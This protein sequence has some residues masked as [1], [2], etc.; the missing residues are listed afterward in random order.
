MLSLE[1]ADFEEVMQHSRARKSTQWKRSHE[2][3][4]PNHLDL[5]Y[6]AYKGELGRDIAQAK[7]PGLEAA[8]MLDEAL[9]QSYTLVL[10]ARAAISEMGEQSVARE[11]TEATLDAQIRGL[12]QM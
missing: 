12:C 6:L 9:S 5:Q 8:L 10:F 11:C 4:V 7:I 3:W 2:V 1:P